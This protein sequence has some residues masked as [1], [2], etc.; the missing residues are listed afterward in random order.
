MLS[1]NIS[2]PNVLSGS[3][4]AV[5]PTVVGGLFSNSTS[6]A[7]PSSGFLQNL[8][9]ERLQSFNSSI[10]GGQNNSNSS[11]STNSSSSANNS[12]S[13]NLNTT[14]SNSTSAFTPTNSSGGTFAQPPS[15]MDTS[16]KD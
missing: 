14:S 3:T 8:G 10:L 16:C 6:S 11:T 2:A 4:G 12:L 1:L 9:S 7:G 13:F 5:G 15:P